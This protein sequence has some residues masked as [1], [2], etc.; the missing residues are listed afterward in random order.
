MPVTWGKLTGTGANMGR[1]Y[2]AE[3]LGT[4]L[5][6]FFG[7]GAATLFL[8]YRL[9]GDSLAAGILAVS[10][11]FG[12][13]YAALV[14]VAGPVAPL[15][16]AV[17]AAILHFA[18]HPLPGGFY[19]PGLQRQRAA[20]SAQATA[21]TGQTRPGGGPEA[22]VA[23]PEQADGRAHPDRTETAGPEGRGGNS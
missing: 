10:L 13:I 21:V 9:F 8:G 19:L 23:I 7:V 2:A 15:A 12:L 3:F 14:Y 6:V 17:F 22:D 16:G 18:I 1:K 4:I 11:T 20:A 5:L